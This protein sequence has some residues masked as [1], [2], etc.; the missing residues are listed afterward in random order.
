M[1]PKVSEF[2][3]TIIERCLIAGRAVWFYLGKLF[4]PMD[5]IFIYPRWNVSQAV[6]WQ[7]LFPARRLI[8]AGALW[9]LRSRSRAPIAVFLYFTAT[10][11]PYL[12]FFNVYPF[13]YSFVADH[14][15]YLA[16]IGPITLTAVGLER[17]FGLFKGKMRR[18]LR[19]ILY[20]TVLLTLGVLTWKQS[21]MYADAETLYR[22]TIRKNPNCWMAYDN[23]GVLLS[24]S[25]RS[26]EAMALYQKALKIKPNDPEAYNNIGNV[27]FQTGRLDEAM[28]NVQEALKINPKYPDAHNNL[29]MLLEKNGRIDEA[30][31]HYRRALEINPLFAEVHNN[32]GKLL[33]KTGQTDEAITHF[34]MALKINPNYADAHNGVGILLAQIGR[35]DEAIV[36]YRKALEINS[37]NSETH[38]NL[39]YALFQTGRADEAIDHLR[40]ALEINPNNAD[41]HNNLANALFQTGSCRRSHCPFP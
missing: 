17:T 31:D 41:A 33:A 37:D 19:M 24:N 7:Y 8:L 28:A 36:H 9:S 22:T 26:N 12:G 32:L 25:D 34:Q 18:F 35:M 3:F 20:V 6:W 2:T 4:L 16:C 23:L 39:G 27:L 14:F 1:A 10:L 11:F 30:I 15:Q 21:G 13:R 40:K 38:L 5:L 29:A